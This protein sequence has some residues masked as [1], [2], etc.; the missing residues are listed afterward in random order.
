MGKDALYT[1]TVSNS[2]SSVIDGPPQ[3]ANQYQPVSVAWEGARAPAWAS[4]GT[5]QNMV[6][7]TK[8]ELRMDVRDA[9]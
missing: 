4:A 9:A 6:M 5:A 2:N 8:Q 7:G 3:V 1:V